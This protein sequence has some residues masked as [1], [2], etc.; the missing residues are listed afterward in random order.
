MINL[1]EFKRAFYKFG[2]GDD[3]LAENIFKAADMNN[4]Q[5]VTFSEFSAVT[6][7][8]K[9]LGRMAL[10][11]AFQDILKT[12][13]QDN[14]GSITEGH[15][16]SYFS[17]VSTK[18]Q[19]K[20]TFDLIDVDCDKSASVAELD[21]FLFELMTEAELCEYQQ[22][23]S[24]ATTELREAIKK[25]TVASVCCLGLSL[26]AGGP[27]TPHGCIACAAACGL[28]LLRFTKTRDGCKA[29]R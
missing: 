4:N 11:K 1:V 17:K 27:C 13:D 26:C 24:A 16:T 14:D 7:V 3:R 18:A 23:L 2:T 10:D 8:W 5:Q 19:L 25:E 20:L 28:D 29:R 15:F 12:I 9:G 6:F 21:H 22:A